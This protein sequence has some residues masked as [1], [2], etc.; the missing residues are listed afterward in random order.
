VADHRHLI[1][2]CA[3]I[4][5]LRFSVR[6]NACLLAVLHQRAVEDNY[7]MLR[8]CAECTFER[9]SRKVCQAPTPSGIGKER[10]MA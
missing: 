8:E 5:L 6:D 3:A 7:A 4:P 2:Q 9:T 10:H 1:G